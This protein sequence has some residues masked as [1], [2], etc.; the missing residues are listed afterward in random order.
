MTAEQ[1]TPEQL[2]LREVTAKWLNLSHTSLLDTKPIEEFD[3]FWNQTNEWTQN[4]F[5]QL[6][7]SLLAIQQAAGA[8]LIVD[9]KHKEEDGWVR[10]GISVQP[11]TGGK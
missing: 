6:A 10:T 4:Y 2:N 11:L 5:R 8:V 3:W 7:D 9:V 1:L